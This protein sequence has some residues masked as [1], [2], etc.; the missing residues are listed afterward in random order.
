M[1]TRRKF[2]VGLLTTAFLSG[3]APKVLYA[4]SREDWDN[5]PIPP[6]QKNESTKK[7]YVKYTINVQKGF[8]EFFEGVRVPTLG[9]NGNI[10][11]P[12][13]RAKKGDIVEIVVNNKLDEETT[14]HWHGIIVPGEMDGGPHQR[15]LPGKQW[16]AKFIVDQQAATVWYHPH[17]IGTTA[18]QV[19]WG[20]GGLFILD[21]EVSENL[22]IPNEYG[23][24][25]I[26][27]IIQDKRFLNDGRLVY[28]T[29]M[30]DIMFGMLGNTVLV[31]G[32]IEPKK[33]VP[34]G[35]VRFRLLNAS[36]ARS[37]LLK[38]DKQIP[39][40]LIAT[41]GG[42]IEKPIEINKIFLSPGERI[43]ILADF[44]SINEGDIV[45]LEDGNYKF[46]KFKI[47]KKGKNYEIPPRLANFNKITKDESF[48]TRDF[49]LS[50][51]GHMVNING[52]QFDI[53]RIDEIVEIG[54]TEI[55]RVSAN[56]GMH[57]MMIN[58]N[59]RNYVI[60]N[61]HAHGVLFQV[62][63]RN[64]KPPALHERGWK[65]TIAL[66]DGDTVE[67]IMKF[68]KKGIFMYHCHILEHEDN[69]MM[70]QF[71]VK[72]DKSKGDLV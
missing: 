27:I 2:N 36:N 17:G 19:Y 26:P 1:I 42:F 12:T 31:N 43:E 50:G 37:Y 48:K 51:L 65:D 67:L 58:N 44:S 35:I 28:L 10:L 16:T 56:M 66:R 46:L 6:V 24:D 69:G 49:V 8:T 21:D 60:H 38:F 4:N 20:L 34:R 30:R 40:F 53:N 18:S 33:T 41:D 23:I 68:K 57:R 7:G 22:N 61:F 64:G 52:K 11:G 63:S 72:E 15:I 29:S 3:L 59:G 70:G 32:A 45:S 5:L 14:V 9:Y 54:T 62:L 55:W 71:L 39:I 13:L 47:G 25:D